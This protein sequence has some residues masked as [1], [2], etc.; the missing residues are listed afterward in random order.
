MH[1]LDWNPGIERQIF[2]RS[3]IGSFAAHSLLSALDRRKTMG[4]WERIS[5]LAAPMPPRSLHSPVLGTSLGT[6]RRI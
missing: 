1:N 6:G 5:L 3:D 2:A 4:H